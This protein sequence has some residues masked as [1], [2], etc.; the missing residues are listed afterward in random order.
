MPEYLRFEIDMAT[1]KI[2][3]PTMR[4]AGGLAPEDVFR[5]EVFD[6]PTGSELVHLASIEGLLG[7]FENTS[8]TSDRCHTVGAALVEL[9][10]PVAVITTIKSHY[11]GQNMLFR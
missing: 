3:A 9:E 2:S 7:R 8:A 1:N 6:N 11:E 4:S 5:P 10:A